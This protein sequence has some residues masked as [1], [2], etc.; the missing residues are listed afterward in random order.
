MVG[1]ILRRW[2]S[3]DDSSTA[4]RHWADSP[5]A[6]LE[7]LLSENLDLS[8]Y[9]LDAW[10]TSCATQRLSAMRQVATGI[11]LGGYGWVEHLKPATSAPGQSTGFIHAPS[12]AHATTAAILRSGYLSHNASAK[13]GL[14]ALD[15]SSRRVRLAL[16]LLDGVRRGQPLGAMLGYRF[17]R[18]LHENHP[19]L[20]LDKYIEVFRKLAP[21]AAIKPEQS[22]EAVESVAAKNV[23]D[24]HALLRR[25][26][27]G[28]RKKTWTEDTIPFKSTRFAFD[29]PLDGFPALIGNPTTTK[30]REYN[31]ILGELTAL[32]D[33]TDAISDVMTAESVYQAVQGNYLRS[34]ASLDAIS[35]GEVPPSEV[36][37]VTTARSG[38]GLTHGSWCCSVATPFHWIRSNG[39]S[40]H[41]RMP[42]P[43]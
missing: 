18:G 21:L 32:E 27:E 13:G 40:D 7:R 22:R 34:G 9:R 33:A 3:Y 41:G 11:Q 35:R 19:A 16:S 24:G 14:L 43:T 36:E 12:L 26:Q 38:V 2:L 4:L 10:I 31:G 37:V 30:Q 23:V 42:R 8:S 20:E 25:F 15:L 1:S 6:A 28:R 17:E 29:A 5:T 39:L